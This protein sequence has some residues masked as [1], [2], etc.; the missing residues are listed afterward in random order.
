MDGGGGVSG[1][2][3]GQVPMPSFAQTMTQDS[4][5]RRQLRA[6]ARL[7]SH[8]VSERPA[9]QS[10]RN[11]IPNW[12]YTNYTAPTFYLFLKIKKPGLWAGR[13]PK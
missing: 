4:D 3:L 9:Q 12:L 1:G 7:R 10:P 2:G 13:I 6:I 5:I 11:K 8:S